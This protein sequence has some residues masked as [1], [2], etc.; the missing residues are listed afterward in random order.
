MFNISCVST[1]IWLTKSYNYKLNHKSDFHQKH[2]YIRNK[3]YQAQNCYQFFFLTKSI[4]WYRY[5]AGAILALDQYG[6]IIIHPYHNHFKDLLTVNNRY[7]NS[8]GQISL[9]FQAICFNIVIQIEKYYKIRILTLSLKCLFRSF[10][11]IQ[12]WSICINGKQWSINHFW[13]E[14]VRG[15]LKF[16]QS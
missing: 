12:T 16:H 15:F 11:G 5:L 4:I 2:F 13:N 8:F 10:F 6:I 3:N 14:T 7:P 1:V 9:L